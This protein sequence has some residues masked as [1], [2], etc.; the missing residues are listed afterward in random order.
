MR[1]SMN[2]AD[3]PGPQFSQRDGTY[4]L[5]RV[6][7]RN[8]SKQ[9]TEWF[10]ADAAAVVG[11]EIAKTLTDQERRAVNFVAE[12]GKANTTEVVRL[13]GIDWQTANKLLQRLASKRILKH[14][15]RTDIAR[16]PRAHFVL[17]S[18]NNSTDD[19]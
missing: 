14:I 9:R 7:L 12:Y 1:E 13:L 18:K 10:D 16:D 6:M 11:A 5:V 17:A 3:L 4:D 15:H 19:G 8:N 2:A